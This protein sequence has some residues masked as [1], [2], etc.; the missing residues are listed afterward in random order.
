MK[1]L[2]YWAREA[3]NL[4]WTK[5][6][7]Q[8]HDGRFAG[9]S[10]F[11]A[12][13][14]N[15][16]YNCLDR[17]LEAGLA[18]K[19]AIIFENEA[20]FVRA[21][22]YEQLHELTCE[23]ASLLYKNNIRAGDRVAIYAPLC[24]EALASMLAVARLGA[25]HTV[26]FAGFA[27]DALVE[28]ISDCKA[29]AIITTTSFQ[30]KGQHIE[31]KKTVDEALLDSKTKSIEYLLCLDNITINSH[32]WPLCVTK[33]ESFEAN[34][35]LFILY[36]SGTTGK[37]KGIFHA[38]GGYLTHA[39]STTKDIFE[40][41]SQDLLWCTA[42]IG[43]ITG[44]S[45]VV[46]GPLALGASVFIYEGALN[47]PNAHRIYELIDRHKVSILYTAPTAI[48][49]FMQAGEEHKGEA[50]LKSLRLL[51]SVGEPINPK[52]WHWYA[53]VFGNNKCPII[54]SWWQTETG[55]MMITPKP[56]FHDQK[57]GSATKAFHVEAEILDENG[58]L[59]APMQKGFLVI[60]EPWPGL[61]RGIW[62]DQER[63]LH[64]YFS[65]LPNVYFTG[66]GALKDADGD[67]FINGRIDDV[68]NVAGHRLGSAE[69]ESALVAH[70]AVAEAAVVGIPD[71]LSGQKL[72][73]F[74]TLK[75]AFMPSEL[76]AD[77]LKNH[78]KLVIGSFAKPA[79][80]NFVKN[81]PKTRSGKIMRRLLRARAAGEAI[82]SDIST[83]ED[84]SFLFNK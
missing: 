51:G 9:G 1:H 40:L 37:P 74:V 53:R 84:Q 62:G 16:S 71:E 25:I 32:N 20:G 6:F 79:V 42:D 48:R 17:H 7:E 15:A 73:A 83:L 43:W 26:I 8:V 82:T 57:P 65:T 46:Y 56:P 77:D 29:K 5:A 47:Y 38:L 55:G 4:S 75:T 34:S 69:I 30:R 31:L 50:S 35:P 76:V 80:I 39:L 3:Q 78:V 44:H 27:K 28:R 24:P 19:T 49:M 13:M 21:L 45:Y 23:I 59:C 22:S 41:S 10:W 70:E 36:T 2:E 68:I 12:G 61:A 60:K 33:P 64:T 67:F 14:L 66:D 58:A 54:D 63:F 72:V 11:S 18:Q 81:L 52:A